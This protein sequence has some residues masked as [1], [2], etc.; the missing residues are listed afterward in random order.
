MTPEE[1][2]AHHAAYMRTWRAKHPEYVTE[3]ARRAREEGHDHE[4]AVSRAWR[5]RNRER[6]RERNRAWRRANPDK[7]RAQRQ[8]HRDRLRYRKH[9]EQLIEDAAIA[10]RPSGLTSLVDPLPD[11]LRAEYILA[12]LEDRDP[13][14]AVRRYRA[15]ERNWSLS[16][17][18]WDFEREAA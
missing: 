14:E 10:I 3:V 18:G 5:A 12:V 1:R 8:R 11:D 16:T 4:L 2:R 15:K 6:V 17:V 9:P 13:D 7:V